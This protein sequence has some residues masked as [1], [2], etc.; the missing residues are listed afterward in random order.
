MVDT[1]SVAK[2]A[3]AAK[4]EVEDAVERAAAAGAASR[5]AAAETAES[6]AATVAAKLKAAGIDTDVMAEAAKGQASELQR[7]L[8]EELRAR[9]LRSLGIAAAIGL[10]VGLMTAR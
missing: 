3:A 1:A 6:A 5:D 4:A 8:A 7:L 10:I 2:R 9:P